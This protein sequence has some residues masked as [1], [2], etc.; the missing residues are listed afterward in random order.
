[1]TDDDVDPQY[2]YERVL[3]TIDHQTS[4]QQ[5]P[6]VRPDSVYLSLVA[7]GK[8]TKKGVRSSLQAAND[9]GDVIAYRDREDEIR[10]APSDA[11]SIDRLIAEYPSIAENDAIQA[12]RDG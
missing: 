11:D 3:Q 7:H 5:R 6:G 10:F 2:R 9:N 4:P 1:V 12:S 8:F